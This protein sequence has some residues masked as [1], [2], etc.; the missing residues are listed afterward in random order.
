[1]FWLPVESFIEGRS[2]E[3]FFFCALDHMTGFCVA[4]KCEENT[5]FF[6]YRELSCVMTTSQRLGNK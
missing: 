6:F 3:H 4:G 2:R 1:M 5:R